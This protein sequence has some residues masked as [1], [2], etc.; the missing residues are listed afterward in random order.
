L[1][2]G[3]AHRLLDLALGAYPKGFEEFANTSVEDVLVH[4]RLLC[5]IIRMSGRG[6]I[7]PFEPRS[8]RTIPYLRQCEAMTSGAYMCARIDQ[9]G[10]SMPTPRRLAVLIAGAAVLA[11]LSTSPVQACDND[12]YPCPVVAQTQNTPEATAKSSSR[13][14]TAHTAR[15][16]KI[17]AKSEV[18]APSN[19]KAAA[20]AASASTLNEQIDR[21]ESQVSAA[22]ASW[23]VGANPGETAAQPGDGDDAAPAAPANAVQLVDPHEPNELDLA[24][25]APAPA[26]SSWLSSLLATL[27]A[28]LA[29]ASA[30]RFIV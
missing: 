11:S 7:A 2:N 6:R 25:A 14:K 19:S 5:A 3:L 23:L 16:E 10:G 4:H 21:K 20:Q 30:L 15:Q 24:A 9:L 22:A 18:Q 17:R 8:A 28:A 29:A 27:G 26:Q 12:R 1:R 13:K